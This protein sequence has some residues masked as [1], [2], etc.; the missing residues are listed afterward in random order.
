M[1]VRLVASLV[2]RAL[3]VEVRSMCDEMHAS[4]SI[5]TTPRLGRAR[6]NKKI[7]H[8]NGM[9]VLCDATRAPIDDVSF[10]HRRVL[11]IYF[12]SLPSLSLS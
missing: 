9:V 4:L 3:L 2:P 10:V 11:I 12:P 1:I 6:K 5:A 7:W 8:A